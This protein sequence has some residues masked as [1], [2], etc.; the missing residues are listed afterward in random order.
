ML[1]LIRQNLPAFDIKNTF[2][3]WKPNWTGI[4]VGGFID[5]LYSMPVPPCTP[6]KA[7]IPAI[8]GDMSAWKEE[9]EGNHRDGY[10]PPSLSLFIVMPGGEKIQVT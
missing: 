9:D 10:G 7:V 6:W 3:F 5:S 8:P 4:G 1:N 2:L